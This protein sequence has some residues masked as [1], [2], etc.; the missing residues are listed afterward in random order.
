MTSIIPSFVLV[1]SNN[2][3]KDRYCEVHRNG[4]VVISLVS[5]TPDPSRCLR[6]L[7][8]RP[9]DL[10]PTSHPEIQEMQYSTSMMCSVVL[11]TCTRLP[12]C[13]VSVSCATGHAAQP[14]RARWSP[15]APPMDLLISSTS[16][17]SDGRIPLYDLRPIA[18]TR[19]TGHVLDV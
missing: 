5:G 12:A 1:D 18:C 3:A 10:D 9:R 7:W 13:C 14:G 4:M 8:W 2:L 17:T 19:C 15:S 6:D 11:V 16:H